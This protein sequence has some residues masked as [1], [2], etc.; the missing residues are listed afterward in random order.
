MNGIRDDKRGWLRLDCKKARLPE[1]NSL[2][3][4]NE[5]SKEEWMANTSGKMPLYAL[6]EELDKIHIVSKELA[7]K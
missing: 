3:P 7:T 5:A 2:M 6:L 4:G 1:P